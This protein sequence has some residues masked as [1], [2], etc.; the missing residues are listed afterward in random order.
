V[1][2][3]GKK[4]A[5]TRS[6]RRNLP[7]DLPDAAEAAL[8]DLLRIGG[9]DIEEVDE[10]MLVTHAAANRYEDRTLRRSKVEPPEFTSEAEPLSESAVMPIDVIEEDVD[11][12]E[13]VTELPVLRVGIF[14]DATH[15]RSLQS[16]IGAA[17]HT[18]SLAA[19]GADGRQR[20]LAAVRER[21]LDAVVVAVPGGEP[22]IDA[23]LAIESLRPVVIACVD[24]APV[25]A[26][27]RASVVGADLVAIR[28]HEIGSI[29]PVMLAANRL[30]VERRLAADPEPRGLVS[31][32]QFQRVLELAIVRAQK[33]EYP[34]SVALFSIDVVPA[35]P[36]GIG[37]IVRARAGNALVHSIR[38]I[39]VAT[40][41]ENDRFLVL[42]PYT[43]LKRAAALAQKVILMVKQGEPVISGGRAYPPRITGAAVAARLGEPVSF[44]RLLKDAMRTLDQARVDGADLAVQP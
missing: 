1:T 38:E 5:G 34:L 6:G 8:D 24:G 23:A 43:D 10:E 14:E 12:E 33:L 2:R 29:A 36:A 7:D 26:V 3:A 19:S 22:I 20:V 16:A 13:V 40:Q 27:N 4:R 15:M 18:V 42:Q 41:L 31:Y 11:S 35:P 28:P 9:D 37:G 21:T 30:M 25:T 32:E 39:D 17:G 44:A